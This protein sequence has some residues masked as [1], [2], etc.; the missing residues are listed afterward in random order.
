MLNKAKDDKWNEVGG[1]LTTLG[2]KEAAVSLPTDNWKLSNFSVEE[3][4]KLLQK[5]KDGEIKVDRDY[6]KGLKDE[7]FSNVKL[8]II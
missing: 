7:N 6:E 1:K 3:Y 4:R 8:N 5:L 2:A